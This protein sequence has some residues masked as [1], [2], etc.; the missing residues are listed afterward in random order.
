MNTKIEDRDGAETSALG[1]T[2]FPYVNGGLFS[3]N[4]DAPRF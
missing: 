1:P 3:G 4:T 2:Q